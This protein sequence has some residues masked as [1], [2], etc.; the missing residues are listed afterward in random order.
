V[1]QGILLQGAEGLLIRMDGRFQGA[2][3]HQQA[4]KGIAL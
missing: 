3:L 1:P 2:V 4:E